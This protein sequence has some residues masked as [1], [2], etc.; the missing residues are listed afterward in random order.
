V[1]LLF[2]TL[3]TFVRFYDK[4]DRQALLKAKYCLRA[5]PMQHFVN[6]GQLVWLECGFVTLTYDVDV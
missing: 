1:F 5:M 2:C 6:A 3:S 4:Q